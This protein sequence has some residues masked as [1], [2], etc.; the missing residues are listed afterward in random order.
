MWVA[1]RP[2]AVLLYIEGESIE[3]FMFSDFEHLAAKFSG[4][5]EIINSSIGNKDIYSLCTKYSE[6]NNA[7]FVTFFTA[8][9]LKKAMEHTRLKVEGRRS[10]M[11]ERTKVARSDNLG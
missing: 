5:F 9:Y 2:F 6:C 10:R 4:R 3:C 8:T 7:F 11:N 1:G